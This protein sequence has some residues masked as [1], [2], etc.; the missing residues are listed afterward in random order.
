MKYSQLKERQDHFFTICRQHGLKI[1]P[2]RTAI[3]Q[4]VITS[5]NH[6]A[7]DDIF[8]IVKREFPRISFD[9]VNRTL[10]TF[11]QI[12]LLTVAESYRGARRFDPNV[13]DHHHLHCLKCGKIL[14]F[15]CDA[16]DHLTVPEQLNNQFA[17]VLSSR[18]VFNGICQDC[19]DRK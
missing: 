1:T 18:V 7:A 3:Y 12:G 15:T 4:A 14:D 19:S 6:P 8:R 2:Q 17:R 5:P 10:L 9:T 13:E 16:F 11:N